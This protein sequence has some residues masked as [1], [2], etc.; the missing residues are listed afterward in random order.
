MNKLN[1]FFEM[2]IASWIIFGIV[3]SILLFIL[4]VLFYVYFPIRKR[5]KECDKKGLIKKGE[6]F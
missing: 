6:L 4:F 1:L 2:S 5:Y 3:M